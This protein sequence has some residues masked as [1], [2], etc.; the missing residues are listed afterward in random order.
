MTTKRAFTTPTGHRLTNDDVNRLADEV[1]TTEY[2]TDQ[3]RR[4]GRPAIGSAAAQLVPVRIDPEL[5]QS[6]RSRAARDHSSNSEVIRA[7]L[8]DYLAS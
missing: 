7:A 5:L 1:A 3:I 2:D 4:R 6:L 8:R